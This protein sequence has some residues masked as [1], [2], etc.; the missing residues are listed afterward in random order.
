LGV[1]TLVEGGQTMNPSTQDILAAAEQ[2]GAETVFILPNNKNIIMAAE[3]CAALT[4]KT[5]IVIPSRSLPEGMAALLAFDPEMDD[6][7]NRQAM[8]DAMT[9]V[10]TGQITYAARDSSFDGHD[11]KE[12]DYIA[13]LDGQLL[14]AAPQEQEILQAL[15]GRMG[16]KPPYYV[17][18]FYGEG[19]SEE[20]AQKALEIFKQA[21]PEAEASTLEGG[22]PVY[23]Y[24]VSA[25]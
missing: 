1:D 13:L 21:C 7:A 14:K 9:G 19:V 20:D 5:I 12:G 16:A 17:T 23:R 4:D 25:E 11:I 6:Q 8:L 3:Q 24:I 15:A 22:Q 18:L 10:S 2:T